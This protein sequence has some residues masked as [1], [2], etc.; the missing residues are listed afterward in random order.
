MECSAAIV[1]GSP[2][3]FIGGEQVTYLDISRSSAMQKN[4]PSEI[5]IASFVRQQDCWENW[6]ITRNWANWE[7]CW[8]KAGSCWAQSSAR[9]F[10][11]KQVSGQKVLPIKSSDG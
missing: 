8:G 1:E 2:D 4:D 11:G 10:W 6:G 3:V 5:T 7:T 9:C